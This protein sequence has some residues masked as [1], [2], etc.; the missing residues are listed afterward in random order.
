SQRDNQ[1]TIK[2]IENLVFSMAFLLLLGV[3]FTFR[4]GKSYIWG[5]CDYFC[6]ELDI[7]KKC[8]FAYKEEFKNSSCL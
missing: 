6:L 8:G 1:T 2:A 7:L 3:A 5:K 4:G